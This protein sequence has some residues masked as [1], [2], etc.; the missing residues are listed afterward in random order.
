MSPNKVN[1]KNLYSSLICR[2]CENQASEESLSHLTSCNFV[3]QNVPEVSTISPDD[4]Y[5]DIDQQ[6]KATHVWKKVFKYLE[7][8]ENNQAHS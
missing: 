5:G 8:R 2:L 4:I 6:I 7:E 1:F 3:L